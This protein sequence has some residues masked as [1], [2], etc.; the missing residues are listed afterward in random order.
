V[1]N[2][3]RNEVRN[4]LVSSAR[5]WLEEMHV[6]GL[7]V[8]AVASMLY[9]DYSRAEGE[10]V[11][12]RHGGRENLEAI[13][14]FQDLNTVVHRDVPGVVTVAEESTAWGGVTRPADAGGLGFSQKWNMGWMHDTLTYFSN[15]PV[16]RK[17]HHDLLTFGLTYAWSENF[18][19]PLSHDEVV[20]LKGSLLGKMPGDQWQR[21]A[22][23][24]ALYAWMWSHPGKQLLFMGAE[25]AQEREWSHDRE[26]DWFLLSDP[27]HLGVRDLLREL[28]RVEAARPALW[29][30]DTVPAGFAWLD[31]DDRTNSVYAFLRIGPHGP[32]ATGER[33][34]VVAVVANLTPVPRHGYRLGLPLSGRWVDALNTDDER[35]G[36]SGVVQPEVTTDGTP[37]QGQPDSAVLTLPP[38]AVRWLVPAEGDSP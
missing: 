16:H 29:S 31:A 4:F 33:E 21:F 32:A 17:W 30:A 22:N 28:N 15:D 23:L 37:W 18:V 35:W 3:G 6:D 7:R 12:N 26:I 36:G 34:G 13:A 20:H 1:F 14:F 24:R 11:P 38:L 10:W 19:L 9:L 8:D 25:L 27:L 5:Y 2:F